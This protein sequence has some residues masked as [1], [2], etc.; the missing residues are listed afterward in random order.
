MRPAHILLAS[1][2]LV[3]A[4]LG[5]TRGA[6]EEEPRLTPAVDDIS[7]PLVVEE[8]PP[9]TKAAEPGAPRRLVLGPIV[10]DTSI[11]RATAV[12]DEKTAVLT[13]DPA[14]QE[15]L[16]KALRDGRPAWGATVIIEVSTGRILALAEHSERAPGSTGFPLRAVAPAASVFKIVTTSALLEEGQPLGEIVCTHGGKTRM[17]PENLEDDPRHDNKCLRFDEV[18][19]RSANVAIAKLADRKL[20]REKLLNVSERF[21]FNRELPATFEIGSSTA[22]IPE[23]RF[24]KA[25]AAAGFG[26]VRL[27]PLH[28]ALLASIIAN[29]GMLIPPRIVESY[30]GKP[31][32]DAEKPVRVLDAKVA[33]E[34]AT[35]MLAT[36]TSG[37][38]FK[39]FHAPRVPHVPTTVAGKTGSLTDRD[40]DLDYTWFVGYAPAESPQVA[41]AT[42]I[43]NDEMLWHVKAP[44]MARDALYQYFASRPSEQRGAAVAGR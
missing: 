13:I 39:S 20:T 16:T 31:W 28:G 40:A 32:I 11:N 44:Q 14:L 25:N 43:V 33:H 26:D 23:E 9:P 3:G 10:V 36:V 41:V 42:L 35:M 15:R 30:D 24:E 37:T 7:R 5:A 34:V 22:A 6:D 1:A 8:A 18:L 29:D 19:P 4:A 21:F 38:A 12:A 2:F 27:S 17:R